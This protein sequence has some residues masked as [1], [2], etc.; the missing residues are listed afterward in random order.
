MA[1]YFRG[2]KIWTIPE[3]F[4]YR[5]LSAD[6]VSYDIFGQ[7]QL[8]CHIFVKYRQMTAAKG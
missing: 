8:Y 7:N 1:G 6:S 3:R 5:W 2:C 4:G